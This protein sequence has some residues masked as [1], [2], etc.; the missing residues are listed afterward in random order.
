MPSCRSP[1]AWCRHRAARVVEQN[2]VNE[3]M[4]KSSDSPQEAQT[5]APPAEENIHQH[6]STENPLRKASTHYFEVHKLG[7]FQAFASKVEQS[8]SHTEN[9]TVSSRLMHSRTIRP[10][11][12]V[13]LPLPRRRLP[14]RHY[15]P[16][17]L[18]LLEIHRRTDPQYDPLDAVGSDRRDVP[19]GLANRSQ[20]GHNVE[21][22]CGPVLRP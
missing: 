8:P 16:V 7:R 1:P 19:S 14:T 11:R 3:L 9:Q 13:P 5:P 4:N 12:A 2:N 22:Q 15:P 10:S 6:N 18:C 21:H 20:R 17:G